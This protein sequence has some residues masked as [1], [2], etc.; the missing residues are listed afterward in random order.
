MVIFTVF[1]VLAAI[2][3]NQEVIALIG[4]VGAYAVPFLLS[5]DSGHI[6]ILLS[7]ISIINVGILVIAVLRYW[8]ILYYSSFILSW[9]IFCFWYFDDFRVEE[10]FALTLTY[11]FIFFLT[12]Y[13]TFLAN[14][15]IKKEVFGSGDIVFLIINSFLFYGIGY[16][17]LEEHEIGEQLLGLFTVSNALVHFIVSIVVFRQHMSDRNLFFLIVGMV[18]VFITIA[19]PVQ[20]DGR[21]VTLLWIGEATLLFWIGRTKSIA[22]YEK[23]SYPL[24]LLAFLSLLHDWSEVYDR[25][26]SND[27]ESMMTPIFNLQFLTS[28]IF[29]ASTGLIFYLFKKKKIE[30]QL[31]PKFWMSLV[32][33]SIPAIVLI[34]VYFSIHLEIAN[35]WD[36][37]YVQSGIDLNAVDSDEPMHVRNHDLPIF[38]A[39]WLSIYSLIFFSILSVVNTLRLKSLFM[40]NFVM[41]ASGII[42]FLFLTGG[43]YTLSELRE[44]Y[45]NPTQSE[46]FDVGIYNVIIRYIALAVAAV[47]ITAN[48]FYI[49]MHA[50]SNKELNIVFGIGMHISI[51]WMLSSEL[52]HWLDIAGSSESYKLGLSILWGI[53]SLFMI[54]LGIWKNKKHLRVMAIAIFSIT[55]IKLFIYDISHLETIPKTILFVSL[56]VLL[57]IISFLYNKYKHLLA[58]ET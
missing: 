36:Q 28:L 50:S 43:L 20:L 31:L 40:S 33:F 27:P 34:S 26:F 19:I 37:L 7:Y 49:K 56:G 47:L 22:I 53:Y 18:L 14:K 4:L 15:L 9:L 5:S 45:L 1:T 21:W 41:I 2:S 32:K 23:L 35:Y 11:S 54:A 12:F 30:T 38:K 39:V 58:D 8:K 55:L 51:L 46:Y 48:F 6:R 3:Y 16:M 17:T 52:I 10:H 44:S 13:A 42:L 29:I 24:I 57:L 25:Y